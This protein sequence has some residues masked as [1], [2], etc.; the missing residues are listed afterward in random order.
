MSIERSPTT[1]AARIVF[2]GAAR[3]LSRAAAAVAAGHH[4]AAAVPCKIPSPAAQAIKYAIFFPAPHSRTF[5]KKRALSSEIRSR[6]KFAV[7][8][9]MH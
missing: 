9:Y 6:G 8:T 1:T 2:N 4:R 7:I 5:K 3:V